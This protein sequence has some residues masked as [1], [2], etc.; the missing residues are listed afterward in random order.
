MKPESAHSNLCQIILFLLVGG[1][2]AVIDLGSLNVF[3]R[4]WPTTDYRLLILYNTIAYLLAI[5][6]SYIWNTKLAFR[7]YA[8]K[9]VREKVYFFIQ[10]GFSLIL[11]NLVFWAA[12]HILDLY[13]LPLWMM[14]N[15]A[16]L[17]AMAIPSTASFLLMKYFVF[18]KWKTG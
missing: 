2:N 14:Q 18:R 10:A 17:L 7:H 15:I 4:L 5:T 13:A 9:D 11:S 6:N 12:L 3:L 16:K 8:Q 1:T